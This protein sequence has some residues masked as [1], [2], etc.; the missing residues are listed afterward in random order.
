MDKNNPAPG[1]GPFGL[2]W[3]LASLGMLFAASIVA[4]Y[5]VRVPAAGA[6]GEGLPS[7]PQLLWGSTAVLLLSSATM[8]AA[9]LGA[10]AGAQGRLRWGMYLTDAL[11]LVFLILQVISWRELYVRAGA[12]ALETLYGMTFYFL[13]V[14][15]ALHVIG[16]LVP[17]AITSVKAQ[18]GRY[19]PDEHEGVLMCS[20]YWHFLDVV[21]LILFAVLV[22]VG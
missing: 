5:A 7:L 11:G 6:W 20:M 19:G 2:A 13:T 12:P 16:G 4:Y 9:L 14:I 21:W 8:H 3:F 15:H 22:L 17:L 1:S 10:R 18:R